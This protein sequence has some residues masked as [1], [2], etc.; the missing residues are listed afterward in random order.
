[1][2][3][4][5]EHGC[6]RQRRNGEEEAEVGRG[7]AIDAERNRPHDR[8]TRAANPGDN[9]EALRKPDQDRLLEC[10]R[11]DHR[12]RMLYLGGGLGVDDPLDQDDCNAAD[13]QRDRD[14]FCIAEQG[15]DDLAER[16][17]END[18]GNERDQ[19]VAGKAPR[20]R[21]APDQPDQHIAKRLPVDD[22]DGE[23]GAG[24]DRDVE[25]RPFVGVEAHQLGR[26]DEMPGR[27]DGEI[28]GQPL[29]DAED[30]DQQQ[31]RHQ[32]FLLSVARR[33]NRPPLTNR[34]SQSGATASS[35]VGM[36]PNA[37][38]PFDPVAAT[39][40]CWSISH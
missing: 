28:F 6:P 22:D 12:H 15:V 31:D 2:L 36:S 24:L 14:H 20:H 30:D 19:Q 29:D 35:A 40:S 8:R 18:R 32:A 1:M 37:S 17:P 3:G 7:L 4:E 38:S 39:L 21:I 27:R 34:P 5:L 9:R 33:R 10:D 11:A 26:E 25:Q 16:E 13:D 23:N